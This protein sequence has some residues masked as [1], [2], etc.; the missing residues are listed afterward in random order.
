MRPRVQILVPQ[1]GREGKKGKEEKRKDKT[2][3]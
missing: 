1:D 2:R 3:D